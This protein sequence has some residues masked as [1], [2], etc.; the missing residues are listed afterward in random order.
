MKSRKPT[1]GSALA[2][3]LIVA[4]V[5]ALILASTLALH[6]M[7]SAKLAAKERARRLAWL[8]SDSGECP[9][10]SC[11]TA[12]CDQA[13]QVVGAG[14]EEVDVGTNGLSLSS[15]LGSLRDFFVGTM[16]RGVASV[17]SPIPRLF[18]SSMTSQRGATELICNTQ[19]RQTSAGD[20]VLE[21]ACR[22]GLRSTEYAREVC[23]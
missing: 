7:Y 13:V 21:H 10:A 3:A 4:P 18:G 5:F 12:S 9:A 11:S 15:F 23:R 8:Q 19:A 22:T 16:T 1:T 17:E 14:L 6:S 20:S 2:E